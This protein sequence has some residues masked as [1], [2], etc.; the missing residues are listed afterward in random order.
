M[1]VKKKEKVHEDG[2]GFILLGAWAPS[3]FWPTLGLAGS[4]GA[5]MSGPPTAGMAEGQYP[6]TRPRGAVEDSLVEQ[7]NL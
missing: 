7:H 1:M 5:G 4:R 2:G 6:T 3:E